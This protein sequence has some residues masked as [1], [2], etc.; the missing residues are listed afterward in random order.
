[1]PMSTDCGLRK[2][3]RM[4]RTNTSQVSRQKFAEFTLPP[5]GNGR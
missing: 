3:G 5:A 2:V 4:D 1:M